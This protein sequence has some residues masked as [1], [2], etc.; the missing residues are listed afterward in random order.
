MRVL[1]L[2][3]HEGKFHRPVV[4][5]I[6]IAPLRV[7]ELGLRKIKV[8]CLC[9]IALAKSKVEIAR[10][11]R[12]A[13]KRKLPSEVEKKVLTRCNRSKSFRRRNVGVSS[14]ETCCMAPGG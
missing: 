12:A 10:R 5:Q 9:E 7:V 3:V 13:P 4:R 2:I 11:I 8:P 6:Q 14:Q 1:L